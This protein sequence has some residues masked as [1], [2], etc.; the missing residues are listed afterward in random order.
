MSF[1]TWAAAVTV[2]RRCAGVRLWSVRADRSGAVVVVV[3]GVVVVVTV[4]VVEA[5]A[6]VLHQS[7]VPESQLIQLPPQLVSFLL[8]LLLSGKQTV[9]FIYAVFT[10]SGFPLQYKDRLHDIYTNNRSKQWI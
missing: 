2:S 8:L 5:V 6:V 1:G 9:L 4:I 10:T 7:R 3:A